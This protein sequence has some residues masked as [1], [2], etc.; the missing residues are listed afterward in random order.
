M[1]AHRFALHV[2]RA[3]SHT[4]R[5]APARPGP[6]SKCAGPPRAAPHAPP[7]CPACPARLERPRPF[8]IKA[9]VKC[10]SKL[11]ASIDAQPFR[12][13]VFHTD[14]LK[15]DTFRLFVFSLT[16]ETHLPRICH[17]SAPAKY[18]ERLTRSPCESVKRGLYGFETVCRARKKTEISHFARSIRTNACFQRR[19]PHES[20]QTA[21]TDAKRKP[22]CRSTG[23]SHILNEALTRE[24]A[25]AG[26][27]AGACGRSRACCTRPHGRSR[28]DRR[29]R[30][31]SRPWPWRA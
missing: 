18:K 13:G 22:P 5:P 17:S 1:G 28:P 25:P 4:P 14:R 20:A 9:L 31:R 30:Q 26:A 23:A 19:A 24:D 11:V 29:S 3:R 21:D 7:S 8:K 10:P 6:V 12:E 2:P 16:S 27:S 15:V